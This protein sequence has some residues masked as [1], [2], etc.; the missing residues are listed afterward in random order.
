VTATAEASGVV[1]RAQEKLAKRSVFIRG[2]RFLRG[3]MPME[4]RLPDGSRNVSTCDYN[5]QGRMQNVKHVRPLSFGSNGV[6]VLD[7]TDPSDA[8][9]LAEARLWLEQG[10]DPRIEQY[11]IH[12][13]EGGNVEPAPLPRYENYKVQAL[14]KRIAEEVD[15]IGGSSPEAKEFLESVA[16]YELQREKPR[17]M[18]LDAIEQI[19]AS[20]GVEHGLDE[21][22]D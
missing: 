8:E 5:P 6:M 3:V 13:V 2:N 11:G 12:I 15:L 10:D 1:E 16:R 18:V 7:P 19:D 14:I 17:K 20:H 21:V 4:R 22:E 9:L